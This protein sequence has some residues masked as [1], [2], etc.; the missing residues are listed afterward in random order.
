V[1]VDARGW[2]VVEQSPVMFR[3][4][5]GMLPLPTP[6]AGGR[7]TDLRKYSNVSE[8]DWPLLAAWLVAASAPRVRTPS[9][10]CMGNKAAPSRP[11]VA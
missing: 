8:Q 6:T 1:E 3:R 10:R 4:S 7:L 11:C 2:R 5:K 9:W